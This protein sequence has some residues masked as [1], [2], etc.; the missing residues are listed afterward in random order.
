MDILTNEE[1]AELGLP[2]VRKIGRATMEVHV[3]SGDGE[4]DAPCGCIA[5]NNAVQQ[6]HFACEA[7]PLALLVWERKG[8]AHRHYDGGRW[9]WFVT[10]DS[11]RDVIAVDP[12]YVAKQSSFFRQAL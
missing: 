5:C 6:G 4:L 1:R 8:E 7:S 3:V 9:R 11:L 10:E 2:P 12:S